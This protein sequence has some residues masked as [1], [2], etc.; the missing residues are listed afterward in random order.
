[1][2]KF[3]LWLRYLRKKKIVFLSI[4][5]VALSCALMI[6][7]DSLFTG[8]V[9]AIEKSTISEVGDLFLW[10]TS[11]S[12]PDYEIFLDRLEQLDEVE[13]AAPF[14]FGG[15][16]LHLAS[17]DVREVM[18]RGIAP[19]REPL[20]TDWGKLL[21]RQQPQNS[22]PNFDIPSYA[23][24]DGCWVGIVVV[25][26]PNEKTNRYDFAEIK[27]MIGKRVVLTTM[28][29]TKSGA[30]GAKKIKRKTVKLRISDV[31][32]TKEYFRDKTIYLPID[33][34]QKIQFGDDEV[35]S[36]RNVKIKLKK[37]IAA[38][39]MKD[40]IRK[41][42][43]LFASE[44]LGL[45]A[46]AAPGLRIRTSQEARGGF[47]AELRKQM[48]VVQLIIGTICT[49]AVLLIFCIFYMIVETRRKDV[50]IIKSCGATNSTVALI[51]TGFGACVGVAGSV[52]GIILGI[53]ITRNI[54]VLEEW[55]RI[56]F[57]MKLWVS[58]SYGLS[59]IPNQV[60]WAA[61]WPIVLIAIAGCC[62]GALIPAIVAARTKPVEILR[63]E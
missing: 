1:M 5:A 53:I 58:S 44:Q 47:F 59:T 48:R 42:W 57:G 10:P 62:V 63:Y 46:N 37:G 60:N 21:L 27:K 25:A 15:G 7:V 26:E 6:V 19:H 16:L 2:L 56:I 52:L 38:E 8:Y 32:F 55:V 34:W 13:A 4:A 61:I 17:G 35:G 54:N 36:I 29:L 24:E 39:S 20:F 23:Q 11:G 14:L 28:G 50:A 3:F 51:F 30:D 31:A 43:A 41:E 33:K 9:K 40:V 49:V 18:I 12:I 22:D 45:A